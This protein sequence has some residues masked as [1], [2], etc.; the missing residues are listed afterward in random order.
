M[1]ARH[2]YRIGTCAAA[3]ITAVFGATAASAQVTPAPTLRLTLNDAVRRAVEN[4]PELAIVRLATE[5]EVT[6][7]AETRGAFVPQF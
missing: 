5:V 2:S 4:N 1:K 3:I 7:E 6:R